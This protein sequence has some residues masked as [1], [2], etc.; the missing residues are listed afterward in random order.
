MM[1]RQ[2]DK[3]QPSSQTISAVPPTVKGGGGEHLKKLKDMPSGK[4]NLC[5][6]VEGVLCLNACQMVRVTKNRN[7]KSS[8]SN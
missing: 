6:R 5:K 3:V 8:P 7:K 2:E 1:L 4:T